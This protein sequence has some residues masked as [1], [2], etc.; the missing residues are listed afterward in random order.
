MDSPSTGA[1]SRP[2]SAPV[3]A[4]LFDFGGTLDAPGVAWKER[5]HALYAEAGI[6]MTPEA[7]APHFYAAD[8][9]LVGGVG[10]DTGLC[11]TVARLVAGLEIT[12]EPRAAAVGAAIAERFMADSLASIAVARDVLGALRREYRIGI[13]SNFYG[14]LD[15]VCAEVGLADL[16][17]VAIDSEVVGASKPDPRLFTAATDA[18]GC[19]PGACVFIGDSLRRDKVGAEGVGMRFIWI[20]SPTDRRAHDGEAICDIRELAELLA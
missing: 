12:L 11:E 9:L 16:I 10:A 5:F 6:E 3:D 15:A 7:F 13:A 1:G 18:L 8:D 4:V 2:S 14:N 19:A 17:D 20:T